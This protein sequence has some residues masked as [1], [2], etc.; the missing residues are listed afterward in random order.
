MEARVSSSWLL[1]L[2]PLF[3]LAISGLLSSLGG[4]RLLA[5]T[6]QAP[7]DFRLK[8]RDRFR[9]KS[10]QLRALR[11][12]PA[13]Y[14]GCVTLGVTDSGLYASVFFPFRF[15]HPP[16]LIP[17]R[18]IT[19]WQEGRFLWRRWLQPDTR[20]EGAQI[21]LPWGIGDVARAEWQRKRS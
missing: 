14:N 1:L 7:P 3:W 5:E 15:M 8:S 4:W 12:F 13:N 10:I 6:F 16:L 21:R 19:G 11:F 9:F 18:D 17:W 2:I 20:V